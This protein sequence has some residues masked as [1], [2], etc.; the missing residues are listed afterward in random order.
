MDLIAFTYSQIIIIKPLL[1][2]MLSILLASSLSE[3]LQAFIKSAEDVSR[4]TFSNILLS[5]DSSSSKFA[6]IV[7]SIQ[8][9]SRDRFLK[10]VVKACRCMFS[11]ME[12]VP[13]GRLWCLFRR[14]SKK[15]SVESFNMNK[16]LYTC[17]G[18]LEGDKG[19]T[20]EEVFIKK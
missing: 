14:E 6:G 7:F 20:Q 8:R 1:T 16:L 15:I 3:L 18:E 19:R 5:L 4:L 11:E 17:K 2:L 10:A 9:R 13:K 12:A